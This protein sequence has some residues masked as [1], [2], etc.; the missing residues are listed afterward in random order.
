MI[1]PPSNSTFD[2]RPVA[3]NNIIIIVVRTTMYISILEFSCGEEVIPLISDDSAVVNISTNPLFEEEDVEHDALSISNDTAWCSVMLT[4]TNIFDPY[5]T[6]H[7]NSTYLI[8]TVSIA[9][10]PGINGSYITALHLQHDRGQEFVFINED[11]GAPKV[12]HHN[13][14]NTKRHEYS[15]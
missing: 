7:F 4:G 3:R 14:I 12:S 6:V 1:I 5:L 10:D 11:S 15:V 8:E 9:G 13:A 2:L